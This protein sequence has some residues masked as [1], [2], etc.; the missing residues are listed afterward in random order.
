[1]P[2]CYDAVVSAMENLSDKDLKILKDKTRLL[3][4]E[5]K[6]KHRA[7]DPNVVSLCNYE[8]IEAEIQRQVQQLRK[9]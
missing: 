1:M 8:E 3:A 4:E 7:V 6:F 2:W 9:I 5:L